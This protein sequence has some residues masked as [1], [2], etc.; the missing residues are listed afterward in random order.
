MAETDIFNPANWQAAGLAF[1]PNPSYGFSRRMG[2]NRQVTRPRLGRYPSR[3]TENGGHVFSLG[4]VNTD[5]TTTDR[6]E[7]FYHNFKD[8]YFTLIDQDWN[9]RHYVG[10]FT[11][12]P[13]PVHTANGKW[14]VQGVTF[15]EMPQA[16]MLVYPSLALYGHMVNVVD[17]WLYPRIALMQ[18]GWVTQPAPVA[19]FLAPAGFAG[20]ANVPASYE[21]YNA[22]ALLNDWVQYGY[23]G[24]GFQLAF[25]L[26]PTFGAV[27]IYLDGVRLVEALDLSNGG[28]TPVNVLGPQAQIEVSGT[29][30]ASFA[31]VTCVNCPLD[32]HLVKIIATGVGAGNTTSGVATFSL[33]VPGITTIY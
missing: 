2:A 20:G 4:W 28:S 21:A 19:P 30:L 15:E 14:T 11:S 26:A 3:D 8:G 6:I 16:R 5:Q 29:Q 10:R 12:E 33:A 1:N 31:V 17:D 23:T 25:R 22:N 13:T 24:F 32:M 27:D 18:G 9:G 7:A